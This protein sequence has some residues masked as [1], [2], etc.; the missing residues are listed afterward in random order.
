M[1][2][3]NPVVR[4]CVQ[5]MQAEAEGRDADARDLFQRAW[6]T[7][8]DDYEGPASPPTTWP[9]TNPLPS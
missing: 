6:E 8:G 9:D 1:D 3:D 2:P 4:L 5:G 7:A